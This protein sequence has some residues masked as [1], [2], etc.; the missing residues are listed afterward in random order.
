MRAYVRACIQVCVGACVCKAAQDSKHVISCDDGIREQDEVGQALW[1]CLA[2]CV[3]QACVVETVT[4]MTSQVVFVNLSQTWALYCLVLF[5]HELVVPLKPIKPFAKFVSI[6]VC[7]PFK[8]QLVVLLRP[9]IFF[10]NRLSESCFVSSSISFRRSHFKS[11]GVF[12]MVGCRS[13]CACIISN[14]HGLLICVLH[15]P[16]GAK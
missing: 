11:L 16:F 1:S 2:C 3:E 6:K 5:Y 9:I 4:A 13:H 7:L 8:H 14:N 10:S 12:G 15:W